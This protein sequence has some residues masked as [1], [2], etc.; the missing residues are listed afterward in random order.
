M[1]FLREW[2]LLIGVGL[3]FLVSC[4]KEDV[5]TDSGTAEAAITKSKLYD[6]WWYPSGKTTD[7]Y[8]YS[9]GNYKQTY[10]TN[11]FTLKS[12]GTWAWE[13]D[14]IMTVKSNNAGTWQNDYSKITKDELKFKVKLKG[15]WGATQDYFD[16]RPI[17]TWP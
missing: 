13:N 14:T 10:T 9:D 15:S 8:F 5:D 11:G 4:K 7:I 6:K 1:R 12:T 16:E 2:V 17:S 3:M